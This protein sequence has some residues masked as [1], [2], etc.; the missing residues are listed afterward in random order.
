MKNPALDDK[1]LQ[2]V[3]EGRV[4]DFEAQY[5]CKSLW[6]LRCYIFV[7]NRTYIFLL[8]KNT[9]MEDNKTFHIDFC[10]CTGGVI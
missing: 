5:E 3:F 8:R 1:L 10:M 7:Y 6:I 2:N 4:Y 9:K